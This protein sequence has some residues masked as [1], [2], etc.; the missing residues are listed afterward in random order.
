M[1][2]PTIIAIIMILL[3]FSCL[4]S[5]ESEQIVEEPIILQQ[6]TPYTQLEVKSIDKVILEQ[7]T[8]QKIEITKGQEYQHLLEI[9]VVNGKLIINKKQTKD[10]KLKNKQIY[11]KITFTN[12]SQLNLLNMGSVACSNSL[13]SSNL[14]IETRNT[15]SVKLYVICDKLKLTTVNSADV[16]LDVQSKT[17]EINVENDANVQLNITCDNLKLNSVNS[18]DVTISGQSKKGEIDIKNAADLDFSTF[19]IDELY[20]VAKNGA[21]GKI[22]TSGKLSLILEN[23]A[24][25]TVKGSPIII[26]K[27]IK[28]VANF[29]M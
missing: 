23:Y 28:N 8:T 10:K 7:G 9:S 27:E 15:A 25:F 20:L 11:L 21:N 3:N 2:K 4:S 12:L 18:A 14:L 16:T 17:S 22:N 5:Q 29:K 1:N 24:S 6:E 13:N 19:N 26:K